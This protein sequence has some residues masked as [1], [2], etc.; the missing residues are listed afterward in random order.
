MRSGYTAH[1]RAMSIRV[2]ESSSHKSYV[3]YQKAQNVRVSPTRI[4][5]KGKPGKSPQ[6]LPPLRKGMLT[7]YGYSVSAPNNT[8]HGALMRA[9]TN[10]NPETVKRRLRLVY[11]YSRVSNPGVARVYKKNIR[12]IKKY[13]K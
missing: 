4:A 6:I 3:R 7:I 5:N 13:V 9:I 11:I 1:R 8:R 12:W 10:S 2:P